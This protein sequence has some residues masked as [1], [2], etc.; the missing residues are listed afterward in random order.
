MNKGITVHFK[1]ESEKHHESGKFY[2]FRFGAEKNIGFRLIFY[3]LSHTIF[4][5]HISLIPV[6]SNTYEIRIPYNTWEYV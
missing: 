4:C 3:F 1:D 6:C 5:N 2:G